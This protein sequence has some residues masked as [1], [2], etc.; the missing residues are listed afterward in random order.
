MRGMWNVLK[1]YLS[2]CSCVSGRSDIR[3]Y[4]VASRKARCVDAQDSFPVGLAVFLHQTIS[5][6]I[7][8]YECVASGASC[9][10]LL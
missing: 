8:S 1:Y 10:V 7:N 9:K 6:P 4:G 3:V 5:Q 2:V